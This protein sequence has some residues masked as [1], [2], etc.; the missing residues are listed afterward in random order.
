MNIKVVMYGFSFDGFLGCLVLHI[1][2]VKKMGDGQVPGNS[3]PQ[4]E[5]PRRFWEE[6]AE[7]S[8]RACFLHELSGEQGVSAC[9]PSVS[10]FPEAHRKRLAAQQKCEDMAMQEGWL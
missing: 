8:S 5:Q 6:K 10:E 4:Q 1:D 9:L 7:L 2:G 3:G